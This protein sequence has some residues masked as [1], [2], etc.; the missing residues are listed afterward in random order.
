MINITNKPDF[1]YKFILKG[2]FGAVDNFIHINEETLL[3]VKTEPRYQD[4]S[5]F[6]YLLNKRISCFFNKNKSD[7]KVVIPE[8]IPIFYSFDG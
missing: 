8:E 1:I 7:G 3:L 4:P 2:T 6:N 5:L